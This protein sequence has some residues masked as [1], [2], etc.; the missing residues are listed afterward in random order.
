MPSQEKFGPKCIWTH[1]M[2]PLAAQDI[3]DASR[4]SRLVTVTLTGQT[5]CHHDKNLG[6]PKR[7]EQD[8]S[9][10]FRECRPNRAIG[11]GGTS[12]HLL[13]P[14]TPTTHASP[15]A[16]AL[17]LTASSP[18]ICAVSPPPSPTPASLIASTNVAILHPRGIIVCGRPPSPP[19][20]RLW[21]FPRPCTAPELGIDQ[22]ALPKLARCAPPLL[23]GRPAPSKS[24]LSGA[25]IFLGCTIKSTVRRCSFCPFPSELFLA[26]YRSAV[27]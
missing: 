19:D 26:L 27:A 18:V 9:A 20:L 8:C 12:P 3:L 10:D 23:A 5:G 2:Q 1:I 15:A 13:L 14:R 22:L 21:R 25:P 24:T 6:H 16:A 7:M 11:G 17:R 4:K